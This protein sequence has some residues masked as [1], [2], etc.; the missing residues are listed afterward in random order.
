MHVDLL[1]SA[2]REVSSSWLRALALALRQDAYSDQRGLVGLVLKL[3]SIR[4]I[5]GGLRRPTKRISP[6]QRQHKGDAE[7]ARRTDAS[8]DL[9]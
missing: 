5:I 7:S 6:V 1:L 3:G 9:P 2:A 4:G 8:P